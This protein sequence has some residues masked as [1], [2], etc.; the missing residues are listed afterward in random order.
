MM[1][2][3]FIGGRRVKGQKMVGP[4]TETT[5]RQEEALAFLRR[6]Y[7]ETGIPATLRDMMGGIGG[8]STNAVQCHVRALL[9]RGLVT[10]VRRGKIKRYRPTV[11]EGACPCCGRP[12]PEQGGADGPA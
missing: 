8:A 1:P 7:L 10:A 9:A 6:H 4:G 3:G 11:P 2:R 12:L 5:P